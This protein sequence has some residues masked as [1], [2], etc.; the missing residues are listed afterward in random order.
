MH[1]FSLKQPATCTSHLAAHH[2]K[3]GERAFSFSSPASLN[4]LPTEL[5]TIPDATVCK[6]K[7]KTYLFNSLKGRDVN[8]LHLAIQV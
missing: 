2:C 4:S 8:W 7:L 5:R 3:F 6:N 1:S